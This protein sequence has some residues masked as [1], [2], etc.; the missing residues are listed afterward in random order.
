MSEFKRFQQICVTR[1]ERILGEFLQI[2]AQEAE[3]LAPWQKTLNYSVAGGKRIRAMLCMAVGM[4]YQVPQAELDIY[5]GA[6][7]LI[8][9]YSLVHDDLPAMDNDLLRRGKPTT[10]AAFGEADAILAGDA[11]NT[12]AFELLAGAVTPD[13]N[14]LKRIKMIQCL[15][16]A[17]GFQGMGAGQY[18]DI[19]PERNSLDLKALEQ[20]HSLKT[21]KLIEASV[22]L[23]LIYAELDVEA[24]KTLLS[25][26]KKFGLIFQIQDD[27]LDIEGTS[28]H[29]GKTPLKDEKLC[30][31]TYPSILGLAEAK[32]YRDVLYQ[33][34]LNLINA[35][36]LE[37]EMLILLLEF[38]QKRSH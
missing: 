17:A 3:P 18:L 30:K 25:F 27:I 11:L 33:E 12:G 13:F 38:A 20:L 35:L 21:G 16:H 10:H 23:P 32:A 5:A 2:H 14:S 22:R 26:A 28:E 36:E 34:A 7:E 4:I 1:V 37:A 9:A 29:L 6:L 8:H 24:Q 15:A 19:H 31:L